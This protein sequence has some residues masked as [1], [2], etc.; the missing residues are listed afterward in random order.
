MVEL[1]TLGGLRQASCCLVDQCCGAPG[2]AIR[3]FIG[4]ILLTDPV[5]DVMR[6]GLR[7]VSPD[8]RIETP[9]IKAVLAA[10]VIKRE[11]MEGDKA[12]AAQTKIHRAASKSLRATSAKSAGGEPTK[13]S[14]GNDEKSADT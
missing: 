6:R 14:A 1:E 10:E 13:D 11:V 7:R 9:Q 12:V 2:A 4:A 3:F 5:L 8:V